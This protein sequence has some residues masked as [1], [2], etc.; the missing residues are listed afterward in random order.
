MIKG[1]ETATSNHQDVPNLAHTPYRLPPLPYSQRYSQAHSGSELWRLTRLQLWMKFYL[2]RENSSSA[3]N[4]N[5][6]WS[7]ELIERWEVFLFSILATESSPNVLSTPYHKTLGNAKC[8]QLMTGQVSD[9]D[10]W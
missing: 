8:G 5:Q 3:I 4:G 2:S 7:S 10:V 9:C 1:M 6:F